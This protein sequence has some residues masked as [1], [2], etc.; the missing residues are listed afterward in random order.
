MNTQYERIF[1]QLTGQINGQSTE[2]ENGQSTDPANGLLTEQVNGQLTGSENGQLTEQ[3]NGQLTG[4]EN[5]QLIEPE[6]EQLIEPDNGQLTE[7]STGQL[8][9][10]ES[11]QLT[12]PENEFPKCNICYNKYTETGDNIIQYLSNCN[13]NICISCS[14]QLINDT[15]MTILCPFCRKT[16]RISPEVIND[17]FTDGEQFVDF[18]TK[19]VN[20]T[21]IINETCDKCEVLN[22]Y[23]GCTECEIKLC[24]KCWPDVHSIGRLVDHKKVSIEEYKN[25]PKCPNHPRYYRELVCTS[26]CDHKGDLICIMCERI[27]QY[28]NSTTD[29][30]CNITPSYRENLTSQL[31]NV[32]NKIKE[33]FDT[34][35]HLRTF[36]PENINKLT[37]DTIEQVSGNFKKM[38]ASLYNVEAKCI[39]EVKSLINK[40]INELN[41]QKNNLY[42]YSVEGIKTS[43]RIDKSVKES[44]DFVLI[45]NY[46]KYVENLNSINNADINLNKSVIKP[47]TISWNSVDVDTLCDIQC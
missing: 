46:D 20:P 12:E 30:I 1:W 4:S 2:P 15:T 10:P 47:I 19:I 13:H 36:T 38:H 22:A 37:N 39:S 3:V 32:N 28:K 24:E 26:D 35:I 33:A 21:E 27:E 25:N 40:Q 42:K 18:L 31:H 29:L 9:E 14:K 5:E 44:D 41:E 43:K 6:N 34:Y 45:L 8:T 16:S 23:F 11:G 7:Q 17:T